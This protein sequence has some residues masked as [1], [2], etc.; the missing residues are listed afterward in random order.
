[1][2]SSVSLLTPIPHPNYIP[3]M[4]Y[5]TAEQTVDLTTW[6]WRAELYAQGRTVTWLARKT[7]R[8]ATT[9]YKYASGERPI[10]QAWL[11]DVAAALGV[12]VTVAV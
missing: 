11:E 10:P 1:M 9:V 3:G 8:A 4:T 7:G 12:K 6:D 5:P 2:A